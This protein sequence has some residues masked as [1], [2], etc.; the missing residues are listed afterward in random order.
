MGNFK[1]TLY[2]YNF[3]QGTS[4]SFFPDRKKKQTFFNYP[5]LTYSQQYSYM[6]TENT[7]DRGKQT[8]TIQEA[9]GRSL[10]DNTV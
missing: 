8:E 4:F 6:P 5:S 1:H 7:C 9:K 3:F 2:L 10:D